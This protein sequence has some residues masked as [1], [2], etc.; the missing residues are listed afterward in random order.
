MFVAC[1]D[2]VELVE[3]FGFVEVVFIALSTLDSGEQSDT[4]PDG[5]R[6]TGEDTDDVPRSEADLG[7]RDEHFEPFN[8][9]DA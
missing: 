6:H 2:V 8:R 3:R 5:Q 7:A 4:D 1:S 9:L